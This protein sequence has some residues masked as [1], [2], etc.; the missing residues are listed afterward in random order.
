MADPPAYRNP[1]SASALHRLAEQADD[2][3]RMLA[4]NASLIVAKTVES[5]VGQP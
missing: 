4:M 2:K 3:L 1:A 5:A